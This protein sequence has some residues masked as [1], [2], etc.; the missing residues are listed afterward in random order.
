MLVWKWKCYAKNEFYIFVIYSQINLKTQFSVTVTSIKPC[1]ITEYDICAIPPVAFS[2]IE[3]IRM[4]LGYTK[5]Q[6]NLLTIENWHTQTQ[7]SYL[8]P[9]PVAQQFD[10]SVQWE[11]VF[12]QQCDDKGLAQ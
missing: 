3:I 1:T 7:Q 12:H 5:K 8:L 6:N 10:R 2:Y 11:M 9:I 4:L